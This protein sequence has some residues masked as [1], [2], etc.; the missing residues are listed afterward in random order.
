MS[1]LPYQLLLGTWS[2]RLQVLRVVARERMSQ[3]YEVDVTVRLDDTHV[4]LSEEVLGR[5]GALVIDLD[6]KQRAFHGLVSQVALEQVGTNPTPWTRYRL[7]LVPRLWTLSKRKRSRVWQNR[8]VQQVVNEVLCA[9]GIPALWTLQVEL[10]PRDYC[11][12]YEETDEAFVLRLLAE[13]GILFYFLQPPVPPEV[14]S[15]VMNVTHGVV[16]QLL[17]TS[18]VPVPAVDGEVIVFADAAAYPALGTIPTGL[19]TLVQAGIQSIDRMTG[20]VLGEV[21]QGLDRAQ[22]VIDALGGP[23]LSELTRAGGSQ[24]LHYRPDGE[25]LSQPDRDSVASFT[26]R[27]AVR[28]DHANYRIYDPRRPLAELSTTHPR[29]TTESLP[30]EAQAALGVLGEVANA[31]VPTVG[32]VLGE[33]LGEHEREHYEHHDP[34]LWPNWDYARTEPKRM[35]ESDRRDRRIADGTSPCP[36]LT[37]G[38]RFTL[39]AHPVEWVN[40]EYVV[41]EVEHIGNNHRGPMISEH[42]RVYENRFKCVP[43]LV[44]FLPK[45]PPRRT[46]QTCLTATVIGTSDESDIHSQRMGEIQVRFHWDREQRGTCWV[47]TMQAWSGVGWGAQFMPRVGM[48]V[49]VGFD[50]GDPDKPIVMGCVYNATHPTPFSL[51]DEQT[52]SGIR[53]QS[54]PGDGGHNELSFEDRRGSERVYVRAERDLAIDVVH[55]RTLHVQHDDSTTVH[56]DQRVEV[57]QAQHVRV[58]GGQHIHASPLRRVEVDGTHEVVTRGD[59][60]QS[61]RGRAQS[62]VEGGAERSVGGGSRERIRGDVLRQVRGNAVE[63]VGSHEAPKSRAVR[64]EGRSELSAAGPNEV[65]SDEELVLRVGSSFVR[66]TEEQ[67]EVHAPKLVL[68]AEDASAVLEGGDITLLASGKLAGVADSVILKSNGASMGLSSEASL[69]GS[70]VLLNSPENASDSVEAETPE[71]TVIEMADQDGNPMAYERYQITLD[72]GGTVSGTLDADGRAEIVL[73]SGGQI[74]FPDLP[75]VEPQ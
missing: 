42:D 63:L 3:P 23:D 20:G 19:Q 18:G 6:G 10:P 15:T 4:D 40:G 55:D 38:A 37:C 34:F 26:L 74:A 72:D 45:R 70:R 35:L 56:N 16:D 67:I 30:S 51:P 5:A 61:V 31:V 43:S 48:E 7:R 33:A 17:D 13:A 8:T 71:P 39:D 12:Q 49:V 29:P 46:V 36:T 11:T 58:R 22:P 47:R 66:I 14:V 41:V 57:V 60:V 32:R 64:V 24:Y 53:T 65:A 44:P 9:A 1:A 62:H 27:D 25:A 69:A 52:K 73:P 21:R 54:T 50:G 59:L 68:R 28:F 2:S 75:E